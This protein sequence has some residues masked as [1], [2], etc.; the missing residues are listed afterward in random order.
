M[1]NWNDLPLCWVQ[2]EQMSVKSPVLGEKRYDLQIKQLS[3]NLSRI[4]LAFLKHFMANF[5]QLIK[6]CFTDQS[7][8]RSFWLLTLI[9]VAKHGLNFSGKII[10]DLILVVPLEVT[11]QYRWRT[12]IELTGRWDLVKGNRDC[13]IEVTA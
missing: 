3:V 11:V 12:I 9:S 10:L 1:Q 2:T 6:T 7:N 13:F 4:S 8:E 5:W